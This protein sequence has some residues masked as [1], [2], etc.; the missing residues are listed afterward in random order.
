M[1][2]AL[3]IFRK[4]I[5]EI[6]RDRR[7]VMVMLLIPLLLYPLLFT[8]ISSFV[9]GQ[10]EKAS[11]EGL[12]IGLASTGEEEGFMAFLKDMP[13]IRYTIVDSEVGKIEEMVKADSVDAIFLFPEGYREAVEQL[14]PISYHYY[15]TST[16]NEFK[17][18]QIR[19]LNYA[20][21]QYLT[22]R[23]L[24]ELAVNA[25]VLEPATA[26]DHN[27]ASEREQFGSVIGGIIP[28]FFIIFCLMGCMYP[29]MDLAAGEKERGTL[30][31]LLVAPADRVQI[32]IGKFLAVA[33]SG[34][35]SAL[36][37]ITGILIS[38]RMI[39]DG[40]SEMS[41]MVEMMTGLLEPV[42]LLSLLG[43]L[44]PLNAF[45]AAITLMLSI[46]ARSFK[47]AQSLITPLMIICIFPAIFGMLPGVELDL[48]T[49]LVPIL[50]VSLGAKE[51]IAGTVQPLPLLLTYLSLIGYAVLA[52]V[53]SVR[54]FN[55]EKNILRG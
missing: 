19:E 53:I 20:Y 48:V 35:F 4:E 9:Q 38:S 13:N 25:R 49:A 6:L 54:F 14:E 7:T 51:I 18:G 47:E 37:A 24:D 15:Y 2:E 44:L 16:N 31:T 46:Y 41:G 26:M 34:F 52:L 8:G 10:E 1:K 23:K 36:A 30:E 45:F 21:Q 39:A 22:A 55:N 27:L 43:I 11:K 28:Y 17:V 42:S 5:K 29:A 33:L 32:Y 12:T 40:Q 3:I 50:N